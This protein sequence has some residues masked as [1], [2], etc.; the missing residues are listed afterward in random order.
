[1][2]FVLDGLYY[3]L[4]YFLVSFGG[5]WLL[6][7]C[8]FFIESLGRFVGIEVSFG[9]IRELMGI[10]LVMVNMA[11]TFGLSKLVRFHFLLM[12]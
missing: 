8:A 6:W 10:N 2:G 3:C 9:G 1:M 12:F 4:I 11:W 7:I 5:C